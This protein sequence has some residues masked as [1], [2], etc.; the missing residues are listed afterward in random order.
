MSSNMGMAR[1][2]S[3]YRNPRFLFALL[4]IIFLCG[5]A[6]ATDLLLTVQDS[7]DNTSIPSATIYVNGANAGRTNNSG[8]FIVSHSG[9]ND[10]LIGVSMSGYKPW[11]QTVNKSATSALVILNRMNLT[12]SVALFNS[13]TL[14][15]VSGATA[16]ISTQNVSQ[17]AISDSSGV[18]YF[19][20]KATTVYSIDIEV[21]NYQTRSGT[22][23]MG[24][25]DSVVQYWLLSEQRFSILVK[26][27]DTKLP[28]DAVEVYVDGTLIGTTDNRGVLVTSLSRGKEYYLEFKKSGYIASSESRLISDADALYSVEISK[29]PI[30]TYIYVFDENKNPLDGV[31]VYVNGTLSG[32]TNTYGRISFP[33][34]VSGAYRIDLKK[35]G[36]VVNSSTI[37]V[38]TQAED[39]TFNLYYENAVLTI[40]V[41]DS[42]KN[43][44]PNATVFLNG[45]DMG[46][47]DN[48]GQIAAT[49]NFTQSYNVS[50]EKEGY[51]T[52]FVQKMVP[53][54]NATDSVTLT[55]EKNFDWG[56]ITTLTLGII[57]ILILFGLVRIFAHKRPRY[58]VKRKDE[59]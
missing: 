8:Q 1:Y 6:Q 22:I 3:M 24:T 11:E 25:E 53:A 40:N 59:I 43:V 57:G 32:L 34:L 38:L 26:D 44:L 30:G 37:L 2:F 41:L 48:Q 17:V 9:A 5:M 31:D 12:L 14:A 39:H 45:T 15:P 27:K 51:R 42:G 23:N 18:A 29:A 52:G 7:A 55:M 21:P 13:D 16:T 54:G 56:F 28:V 35:T 47:T 46:L 4:C 33:K 50:A 36:Y 19:N 20:V 10:Q 58:V 49:V